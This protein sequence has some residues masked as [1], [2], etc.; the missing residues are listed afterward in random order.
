MSSSLSTYHHALH[1]ENILP[2]IEL[3]VVDKESLRTASDYF[4]GNMY[5]TVRECSIKDAAARVILLPGNSFGVMTLPPPPAALGAADSGSTTT[6]NN[7]IEELVR[8]Q[9]AKS[10]AGELPVGSSVVVRL[11]EDHPTQDWLVYAPITRLGNSSN[12][13]RDHEAYSAIMH[14]HE[15]AYRTHVTTNAYSAFRGALLAYM[16]KVITPYASVVAC[17][18][19]CSESEGSAEV[20]CRQMREAY[21]T[22][23]TYSLVGQDMQYYNRHHLK[24]ISTD[25]INNAC[26]EAAVVCSSSSCSSS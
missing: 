12:K 3:C 15:E 21:N 20:A 26:T 6:K 18:L 4:A 1:A 5:F 2:R 7:N 23:L 19:F 14:M 22:L 24:L 17:P 8:H 25:R 9:I 10:Y 11:P 16:E 13:D